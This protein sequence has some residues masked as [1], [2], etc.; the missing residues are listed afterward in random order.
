MAPHRIGNYRILAKLGEG[1]MGAVYHAIDEMVEREVAIKVLRPAI[2]GTPGVPER[3]RTEAI[4]LARLNHPNI[5]T[6]YSFQRDPDQLYMVMEYVKGES[7]EKM[8]RRCGCL[9]QET[10]IG[11]IAQVLDALK[12]AH[13]M[14]ILHRDVKPA[15]ILINENGTA[16]VTD[17]GIARFLHS[18]RM[19]REGS[20]VGTLEYIAP[21]RIRGQDA[22]VPSDLYSAGAMLFEMLTGRLPFPSRNEFE[23]LRKHLDEIPPNMNDCGVTVPDRLEY[24]V[25]RA[26]AKNPSQRYESAAAFKADLLPFLPEDPADVIAHPGRSIS[27]ELRESVA[28]PPAMIHAAPR[29]EETV[30]IPTGGYPAVPVV[31]AMLA[32][33]LERQAR[34]YTILG[35]LAVITVMLVAYYG[36]K[37]MRPPPNIPVNVPNVILEQPVPPGPLPQKFEE[38][39]PAPRQVVH[40]TPANLDPVSPATSESRE[41]TEKA[42]RRE[43]SLKAL[44]Q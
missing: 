33:R 25:Q 26:L 41:N 31:D 38:P 7:L 42:L 15:N 24:I 39:A 29:L 18:E 20:I 10:A 23:L 22:E 5:A 21:E 8:I 4:A 16:K 30:R 35:A 44:E 14:G 12:H 2:A 13:S 27:G 19:T 6:L 32:A 43:R 40:D 28:I 3:F 9:P 37:A 1:G 36:W 17:F 34:V 11:I